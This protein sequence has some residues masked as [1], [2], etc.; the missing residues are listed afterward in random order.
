ME[1][2][3]VACHPNVQRILGPIMQNFLWPLRFIGSRIVLLVLASLIIFFSMAFLPGDP[4][5]VIL[6]VDAQP[7]TLAALHHKLGLDQPLPVQYW[8]WATG[9]FQGDFGRS[10]GYNVPVWYLLA[11]RL[12]VSL[13]LA[14][15]ALTAAVAL[16]VAL[17]V[18]TATRRGTWLDLVFMGGIQ[19]T[20]AVPDFWLAMLLTG[21]FSLSLHWFPAGGFSGWGQGVGAALR[22]LVLP[23]VALAL[24]QAAVLARYTRSA[25]IAVLEEPFILTARAHGLSER[26]VLFRHV[27]PRSL[28]SVL[29]VLS[30]Q[31]PLL[32]SGTIIVENVFNL[33]GTG[34]LL[35]EA[36]N[37]RDVPV[38]QA[39]VLLI[40]AVVVFEK[41]LFQ[42]L[43]I[44]LSP[45][46]S[47]DRNGHAA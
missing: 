45:W 13:P 9:F 25:V 43:E 7:D 33:K 3:A 35:L 40:V 46:L 37:Q 36:V 28:P 27:L 20:K 22:S 15:F 31:I 16:G 26:Q 44:R 42:W 19:L 34:A 18:F 47:S 17:G 41:G 4:A 1:Q 8:H 29:A 32:L 38:V 12:Q 23:A 39:C 30:L 10:Y 21:F 2:A 5:E 11:E 6:G 24:P 14:G